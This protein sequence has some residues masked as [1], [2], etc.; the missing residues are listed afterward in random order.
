MKFRDYVLKKI[1]T[2]GRRLGAELVN[3]AEPSEW[4][5]GLAGYREGGEALGQSPGHDFVACVL[6]HFGE[7]RAQLFQDLFVLFQTGGKR[8]GYFVEFGAANGVTHSNS[9]LLERGFGWSG[10]LA[11]PARGWH[12]ALR[13]NRRCAVDTRC[14]WS[15]SGERLAFRE[16]PDGGLSTLDALAG[17][18]GFARSRE[19]GAIYPVDTVS[20]NELLETHGAPETLDYLSVDTEG[21]ELTILEAFDFS[22]FDVRILTVEHNFTPERERLRALLQ[23]K[24]YRRVFEKFSRWDDW[25]VKPGPAGQAGPWT[26]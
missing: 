18:D 25:Y 13:A 16:T 6:N 24:G 5:G 7:S 3:A 17:A 15:R 21:S 14:V 10:I 11:E 23:A 4:A 22:R 8:D 9:C 2:I 19:G 12:D 1:K 26:V 20:L